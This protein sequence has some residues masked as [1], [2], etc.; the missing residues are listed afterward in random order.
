MH[1]HTPRHQLR[2]LPQPIPDWVSSE[3]VPCS[4]RFGLKCR[5]TTL[6]TSGFHQSSGTRGEVQPVG[7][8]FVLATSTMIYRL[9]LSLLC[10]NSSVIPIVQ[11]GF[12][13]PPSLDFMQACPPPPSFPP[14][15]LPAFLPSLPPSLRSFLASFLSSPRLATASCLASHVFVTLSGACQVSGFCRARTLCQIKCQQ[16]AS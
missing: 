5:S 2:V 4:M 14:S 16:N 1:K 13:S 3:L 8:E 7:I 11:M 15:L 6:S 9:L 10:C 12:H